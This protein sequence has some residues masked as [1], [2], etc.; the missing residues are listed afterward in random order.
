MDTVHFDNTEVVPDFIALLSLG[1]NV[2]RGVVDYV[3][4]V[5]RCL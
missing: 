5:G 1:E 4:F 2:E 3:R